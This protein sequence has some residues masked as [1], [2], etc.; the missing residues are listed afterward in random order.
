MR[1]DLYLKLSRLITRRTLAKEFTNAGLVI[2]N[3]NVAK[4]SREVSKGDEITITKYPKILTVEVL[5]VP[6]SKQ[7]SK[8]DAGSMYRVIHEEQMPDQTDFLK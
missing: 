6:N 4:S 2:V 1:L 3:G 8:K 5:Q 7:V